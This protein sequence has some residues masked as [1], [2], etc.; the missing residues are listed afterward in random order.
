[1]SCPLGLGGNIINDEGGESVV[2]RIWE[3]D[4][5]RRS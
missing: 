5:F 3:L 1:M 4:Q 2:S